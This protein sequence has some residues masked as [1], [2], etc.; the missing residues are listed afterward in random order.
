[1]NKLSEIGVRCA[2][3]AGVVAVAATMGTGAAAAGQLPNG[4]KAATGMNG[5]SIQTWRTAESA[6]AA[7]S[8][9]NNGAGRAAVVSGTYTAKLSPGLN[10]KIA[11]RVLV[12]CQVDI[13]G[14]QGGISGSVTE[15][16]SPTL[17][18]SLTIPLKPGQVAVVKVTDKDIKKG[19]K[20]TLQLT[21]FGVSV[22]RCGGQASARTIVQAVGAEGF[23]TD[24]GTVGGS[25]AYIQTTLYGEP[26]SLN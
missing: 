20:T 9:A 19:G 18:G 15:A 12:G 1:M 16:L 22:E 26:F 10:G 23:N 11:V 13:S 2:V 6:L 25:G 14:L 4:Y 5:A 21:Q 17:S 3:G 8:V 24:N 7:P